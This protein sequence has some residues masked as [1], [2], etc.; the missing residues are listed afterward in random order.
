MPPMNEKANMPPPTRNPT[1]ASAAAP[2]KSGLTQFTG[3]AAFTFPFF[4]LDPE[5]R[6]VDSGAGAAAASASSSSSETGMAPE[7]SL[8]VRNASSSCDS[9]TGSAT[10]NGFLHLGQGTRFPTALRLLSFRLALQLGQNTVIASLIS[11]APRIKK[12]G[13]TL[14]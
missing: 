7:L 14:S 1:N 5:P 11:A 4:L 3:A 6:P 8:A 2:I 13:L 12:D 9:G 10:T